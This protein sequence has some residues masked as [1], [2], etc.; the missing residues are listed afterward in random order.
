MKLENFIKNS[1]PK[2]KD[3]ATKM[4]ADFKNQIVEGEIDPLRVLAKFN[5]LKSVIENLL[6][7]KE[8]RE[9]AMAEFELYSEKTVGIEGAELS[10]GKVGVKYD[11]SIC[12][13]PKWNRL[14]KQIKDLS[15][16]K[17]EVE[18]SLKFI[19]PTSILD[20]ETGEVN[21]IIPP[22]STYEEIV[23]VKLT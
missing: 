16:E 17:K 9:L 22:S 21:Q 19:E 10:C 13:H 23:K 8:V 1:C 20:E 7:D 4:L 15:A 11:Y 14:N 5:Q 6:K 2:N 3:K 18:K 12:N